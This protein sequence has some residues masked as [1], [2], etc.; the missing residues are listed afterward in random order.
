MTMSNA[1]WFARKLGVPVQPSAPVTPPV[2]PPVFATQPQPA[3]YAQPQASYPPSQ[4][5]TPAPARCPECGSGNYSIAAKQVTQNGQVES[6]RCYDCG[7]PI[8]QAGSRH[9]GANSAP[10]QGGAQRARQV[11]TGGW[12]PTTIIGKL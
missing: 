11:P 4:Q 6:W 12:N 8:V 3:T 1:D 2:A 10:S 7:Y 9:G 5:V